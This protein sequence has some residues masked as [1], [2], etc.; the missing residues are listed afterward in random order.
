[1]DA[2]N[3]LLEKMKVDRS[4]DEPLTQADHAEDAVVTCT[5]L[6]MLLS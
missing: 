4:T 1:M 3:T 6:E 2:I 5:I